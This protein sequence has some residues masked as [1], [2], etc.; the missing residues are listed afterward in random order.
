MH[1]PRVSR[2]ILR[3]TL[4]AALASAALALLLAVQTTP[5]AAQDAGE[6]ARLSPSRAQLTELLARLD[7]AAGEAALASD[8]REEARAEAGVIRRRLQGG[9][10]QPGDQVALE[11]EGEQALTATFTVLPGPM[12]ALPGIG[13]IPLTGVLRTELQD[14]MRAQLGRYLRDPVVR[15]RAMVRIAVTG[16]VRNPGFFTVPSEALLSDVIMTAGGPLPTAKLASARVDR[17]GRRVWEGAALREALAQGLTLDQ[18]NLRAGDELHVPLDGGGRGSA[19]L[20]AASVIPG[21]V[22]AVVGVLGV[23]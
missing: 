7:A 9:D 18:M 11:V 4:R 23:F 20:R 16:Q 21:A 22:L 12:L 2:S 17:G 10:F 13:N 5:C 8:A 1:A 3:S 19:V 14:H 15:A 6:G